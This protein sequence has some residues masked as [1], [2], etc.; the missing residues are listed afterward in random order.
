MIKILLTET[1]KSIEERK[2]DTWRF[3]EDLHHL[4]KVLVLPNHDFG[5]EINHVEFCDI[6]DYIEYKF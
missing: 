5:M 4:P 3:I 6:K 2:D 1:K